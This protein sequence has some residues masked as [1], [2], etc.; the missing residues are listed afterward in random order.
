L[1]PFLW[2][3]LAVLIGSYICLQVADP[4]LWWHIVIGRW[5]IA[6]GTVPH[7]DLWNMFGSESVFRAYSWSSEIVLAAIESSFGD[8][9][10][11]FAQLA[12]GVALAASLQITC[13][14]LARDWW[15]GSFFGACGAVACFNHFTLRPQVLVWIFFAW[16]LL[17]VERI[18]REGLSSSR[19]IGLCTLGL[20]WA[21]THLTAA[22][23]FVAVVL[24]LLPETWD[25][26]RVSAMFT[27]AGIFFLGTLV[28]PY[29]GGEWITLL[30]KSG[31]PLKYSV[32]AEFSPATIL[33]YSTVFVLL[34]LSL[35]LVA[36]FTTRIIPTPGRALLAGGMVLAGLTA[37]K[38]LPFAA[39]V[40]ASLFCVWWRE[41]SGREEILSQPGLAD[42]LN[43]A[44]DWCSRLQPMSIGAVGFFVSCLAVANVNSL[45]KEPID[46]SYVPKGPVDFIIE[47]KLPYPILN[48]FGT[49]G[50]LMYRHSD[51]QGVPSQRVAID[52][53]TNVNPPEVWH[54]YQKSLLGK[55][56]WRDF[57]KRVNPGTILWRQGSA[58]VSLL[59]TSK[60]WCRVYSSGS[61]ESDYVVFISR[62]EFDRRVGTLTSNNCG[63]EREYTERRQSGE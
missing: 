48:E 45:I 38:F 28:T 5:I 22:L 51:M 63:V 20:L 18:A 44:R 39:I 11:L 59:Y 55:A 7:Q 34:G 6:H 32:I 1:K 8:T 37:V 46:L 21:N 24:W 52:G 10:L 25:R 9:G 14:L 56:G 43:Q 54:D 50:Y 58:F 47:K 12:L 19:R 15:I 29:F 17:V 62:E 41:V 16:V 27:S 26:R 30:T 31:H 61:R 40:L 57:I 4:D 2:C 49:G 35:L 23:G 36:G 42:F 53:R 60:E 13:S 3:A 33:Q